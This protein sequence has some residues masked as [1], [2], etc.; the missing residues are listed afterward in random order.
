[1]KATAQLL[2]AEGRYKVTL[3]ELQE[4]NERKAALEEQVAQIPTLVSKLEN[5]EA[6]LLETN[7]QFSELREASGRSNGQLSA[8]LSAER[9]ACALVR[10]QYEAESG[11]RRAADAEVVRLSEELTELRTSA[12]AEQKHAEEK[13]LL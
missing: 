6:R 8:E 4:A 7:N 12:E 10:K 13:L 3:Q 1:E 5:T 9:E 11:A 2:D